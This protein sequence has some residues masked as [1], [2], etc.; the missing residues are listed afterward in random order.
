LRFAIDRIVR[1][2]AVQINHPGDTEA[3][4]KSPPKAAPMSPS[5]RDSPRQALSYISSS[6]RVS[7]ENP[8]N[9]HATRMGIV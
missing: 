9:P 1:N 2:V 4:Q 7:N 6:I 5:H 8:K 3:Q